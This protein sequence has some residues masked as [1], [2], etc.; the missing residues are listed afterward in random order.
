MY[1]QRINYYG[2]EKNRYDDC[3]DLIHDSN[4]RHLLIINSWLFLLSVVSMVLCMLNKCGYTKSSLNMYCS[5]MVISLIFEFA[6]LFL[7]KFCIGY[8]IIFVHLH[9]LYLMVFGIYSSFSQPATVA[10]IF[11]V[12]VALVSVAYIDTMIRTS[13]LLIFYSSVFLYTSFKYKAAD[14][15]QIDMYNISIILLLSLFLHFAFQNSKM[16]QLY[17][18]QK[19]IQFQHDLEIRSGF[20][21]LTGLL[22]R[23]RFFTIADHMI[24]ESDNAGEFIAVC[25]LD[26]DKFKEININLGHQMGD[27]AIQLVADIIVD[28]LGIDL[29]EK[30]SFSERAVR[31]KCSIAGRLSGDEYIMFIRGQKDISGI[32]ALLQEILQSMNAV[33]IGE[34]HGINGSFGVSTVTADDKD[35]DTVYKR[36]D[37]ALYRSKE[38]GR[39]HI[40]IN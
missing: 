24:K 40:T 34:L 19:N 2:F 38:A 27:K 18:L 21:I 17:S 33:D 8:S 30:W 5:F 28:K 25:V 7:K 39:N 32:E 6:N 36:A 15:A 35:M 4:Y 29:H 3:K 22:N 9:F 16:N 13:V 12:S 23:S 14:L 11:L 37:E 10:T 26:L 31:E 1:W 20:D